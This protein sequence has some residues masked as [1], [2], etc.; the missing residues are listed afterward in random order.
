M[1]R[2][3]LASLVRHTAVNLH[4]LFE[5]DRERDHWDKLETTGY[6]GAQGAGCIFLALDTGRLLLAKRSQHVEQPGTYGTFGGAID[7]GE[8]PLEA[9]KREVFEETGFTDYTTIEP[10]FVFRDKSFRYYN[11]LV[12]VEKEFKPKL[13]WESDGYKWC[14]FGRWPSPLHFGVRRLLADRASRA[15]IQKYL[16]DGRDG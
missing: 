14:K 1:R 3:S 2:N 7:Q 4:D 12:V 8:A 13:N 15:T 6:Y 16:A 9:A 10:L 5:T 11:F